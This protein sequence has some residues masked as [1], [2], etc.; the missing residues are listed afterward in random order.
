[1]IAK[2]STR[3]RE[4]RLNKGLR[5]EQVAKL[6]GVNKSAISTYENDTR[7]PS[8]EILVRLANL[9]RVST[10]YLL[11]QANSRSVDLSGLSEQEAALVCELVETLTKKKRDNQQYVCLVTIF[12]QNT[13]SRDI[14]NK[15]QVMGISERTINTAKKELGVTSYRKE[16]AWFWHL[17]DRPATRRNSDAR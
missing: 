4:L 11:G 1:M 17:D 3:L 5:Q 7:Q 15:L 16:G 13:R 2:F 9:Y 12:E 8:F 6:I 10:D 14:F